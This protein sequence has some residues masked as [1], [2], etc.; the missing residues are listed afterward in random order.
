[1]EAL[2]E[3]L[4]FLAPLVKEF[5]NVKVVPADAP[6]LEP[7]EML[8]ANA[9]YVVVVLV[10]CFIMRSDSVSPFDLKWFRAVYNFT[11]VVLSAASLYFIVVGSLEELGPKPVCNNDDQNPAP[12][13]RLAVYIFYLSKFLEFTDTFIMI[14]RKKF[15]QVTF[16]HVYHHAS[17]SAVVWTYLRYTQGGDEFLAVGFNSFVHV[18]MYSHYFVTTFGVSAPWK[19]MLTSLQLV[20]FV[21]IFTQAAFGLYLH[22]GWPDFLNVMQMFYMTTMLIL[23][24]NFFVKSYLTKGKGKPKRA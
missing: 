1:M 23:F 14:L 5:E 2:T 8:G 17:I 12:K 4:P 11:C 24:G 6:M 20:Q 19:S 18:L 15:S 9:L 16:L 21:C 3:S 22:C 10:G 7:H 13:V